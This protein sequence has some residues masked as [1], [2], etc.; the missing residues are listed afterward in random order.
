MSTI[1][2]TGAGGYIGSV[3]TRLLLESGYEVRAVDRFFFGRDTLP[4]EASGLEVLETDIRALDTEPFEG[5]GAVIDLAALSNDP[6]SE[7]AADKTW[8]INHAGRV[9]VAQLARSA[10][11]AR[12]ILPSSCSIYGFREGVLDEESPVNPL[13]TYAEANYR[14]EEDILPLA[15][16]GFCVTVLRQATV[17]GL[18]HRMRYDLAING[19]T[20]GVYREGVL[21]ILRDGTQWRPFVHVRDT[22]KA[23]MTVLDASAELVDG[24]RF[25]VG[26]NDQNVQVMPLAQRVAEAVGRDFEYT[27]YGLPD[28]RSYQVS[29]D[30]IAKVLGFV[31]DRTPEDGAREVFEAL[32]EGRSDPDDP[33]TITVEW[34]R[35]LLE[36]DPDAL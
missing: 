33:R 13:T 20:R 30:K 6:A 22:C 27:W 3:L 7:L 12:Y 1:L 26:S 4:E 28:H 17:Y 15:G 11:V 31:P 24:E 21:P 32:S 36:K 18:S 9:R 19:M 14:A 5:V 2:V 10:G 34:Y 35:T 23:M 29:F 16:D 25:N 8:A